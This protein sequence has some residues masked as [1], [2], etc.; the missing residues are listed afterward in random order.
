MSRAPPDSGYLSRAGR[1]KS[2]L[3]ALAFCLTAALALVVASIASRQFPGWPEEVVIGAVAALLTWALTAAFL[4][5]DR[6]RFGDVG[7]AWD[8]RTHVRF[9]IGLAIGFALVGVHVAIL[10]S[11]GDVVWTR[12]SGVDA[13]GTVVAAFGYL[14]LALR[15]EI[16]F[17][18]YP[19]RTLLPAFGAAGAQLMVMAVF[20][21]EHRLGGATW[22]N[23]IIGAGLGALVFGMAA[24]AT[25]GIALALGL[26]AAWNFGDWMRGGKQ[27]HGVWTMHI[28]KA[29]SAHV[30]QVALAAYAA[31]MLLMLFFFAVI[32]RQNEIPVSKR[33]PGI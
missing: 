28:E 3:H 10:A 30:D 23:A 26:H 5:R 20:V 18:G 2:L 31:I 15:E 17:R 6:K 32:H 1:L 16:A 25:R 24:L 21:A 19:L 8:R 9:F 11:T 4:R 33:D 22:S 13:T 14:L 29:H 27:G 12:N 7:L